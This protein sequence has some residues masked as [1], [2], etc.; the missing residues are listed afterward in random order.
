MLT[1]EL[2]VEMLKLSIPQHSFEIPSSIP[3]V[4]LSLRLLSP[5]GVVMATRKRELVFPLIP[6]GYTKVLLAGVV[7]D[8]L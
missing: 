8:Q 7:I 4:I 2:A 3:E 5:V 6:C 1:P